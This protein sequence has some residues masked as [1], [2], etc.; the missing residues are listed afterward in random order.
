LWL[1]VGFRQ[2]A[3]CILW[4]MWQYIFSVYKEFTIKLLTNYIGEGIIIS[5]VSTQ[6]ARVLTQSKGR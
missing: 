1:A 5:R 4:Q 3:F 2:Q 6:K